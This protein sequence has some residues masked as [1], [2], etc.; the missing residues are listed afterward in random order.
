MRPL[1]FTE[2]NSSGYTQ[3]TVQLNWEQFLR[4]NMKNLS[5]KG[6]IKP[7][8]KLTFH[9]EHYEPNRVRMYTFVYIR[10]VL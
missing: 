8:L 5:F 2:K 10:A 1:W 9:V 6:T 4:L 3:I 7:G